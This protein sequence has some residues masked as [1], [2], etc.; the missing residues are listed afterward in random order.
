MYANAGHP[1]PLLVR[2]DGTAMFLEVAGEPAV[3][4]ML[5]QQYG[6]G[7][8]VLEPGDL[9][10]MYSD[11]V[12]EAENGGG[13]QFG[14]CRLRLLLSENPGRPA[15]QVAGALLEALRDF[16]VQEVKTDDVTCVL[17]RREPR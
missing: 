8:C 1:P 14:E 5:D 12:T 9:L 15:V 13:E 4:L 6:L 10:F 11:G 3:G 7:E 17:L 2:A 16:A